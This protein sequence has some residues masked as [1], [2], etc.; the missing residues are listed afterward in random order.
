MDRIER[1]EVEN[2]KSYKGYQVIG[3]FSNFTAIIGPNGA[4]NSLS[5]FIIL[6]TFIY[7]IGKSNLMDAISFVL[8][9]RSN[10]LRGAQLTDLVYKFSEDDL[11]K[12]TRIQC[13]VRLI[14]R[15]SE[16]ETIFQRSIKIDSKSSEYRIDNKVVSF[17]DYEKRLSDFNIL[18]KAKNFLVF[19]GDVASVA[20]KTPKELTELIEQVSG[21]Y[22]YKDEYERL[23]KE[24]EQALENYKFI[25]KKSK[26]IQAEKKQYKVQKEE[27]DHYNQLKEKLINTQ[28]EHALFQLFY[29]KKD[30]D[31]FKEEIRKKE[32][33]L[34]SVGSKQNESES[35]LSEVK[36]KI[37]KIQN[38]INK[39][40]REI[41]GKRINIEKI[42]PS[43]IK[44]EKNVD[45]IR[46][47]I[48]KFKKDIDHL[49]NDMDK[50]N[51]KMKV[52]EDELK[53]IENH[54]RLWEKEFE[55][56]YKD[57]NITLTDA[58]QKE[59]AK[60][61]EEARSK[62]AID[63]QALS[64]MESNLNTKTTALS[65]IT[66]NIESLSRKKKQD[67]EALSV[68][69]NRK[70]KTEMIITSLVT[71]LNKVKDSHSKYSNSIENAK[72]SQ[73]TLNKRLRDVQDK[74]RIAKVEMSDNE[75]R[76]KSLE[77]LEN[78]KRLFPNVY[79][80]VIDLIHP[81]KSKYK[82]AVTVAIGI[83]IDSIVVAD[84]ST[85]FECIRYL[86]EQRL[87]VATFL[88]LNSLKTQV[89]N[90]KLRTLKYAT[91]IIDVLNYDEQFKTVAEYVCG[92]TLVTNDLDNA[93]KLA[94]GKER[95]KVVTLDGTVI[96]KSGLMTGG[97]SGVEQK[98][99]RWDEKE[100]EK[101][102]SERDQ[103]MAEIA[104]NGRILK[105]VSIEQQLETN[106]AEIETRLENVK[107]DLD[108]INSR[109][110]SLK[111]SIENV[112]NKIGE[113]TN[114]SNKLKK[115]IDKQNKE[116]D[117]LKSKINSVEDEIYKD[118]SA[119][120]GIPNIRVYEEHRRIRLKEKAEKDLFFSTQKSRI[121]NLMKYEQN[122]DSSQQIKGLEAKI[123][124]DEKQLKELDKK[125]KKKNDEIMKLNEEMES[126]R[127]DHEE[128]KSS[129]DSLVVE[130]RTINR[131][132][133]SWNKQSHHISQ[134]I[135]AKN[136]QIEQL[137][138]KRHN[139]LNQCI[140]D[141]IELPVENPPSEDESAMDIEEDLKDEDDIVFDFSIL[142]SKYKNLKTQA[143]RD[144]ANNNFLEE[145]RS[146]AIQ[147]DKISPNLK[148]IDHLQ[149]VNEKIEDLKKELLQARDE[150]RTKLNEFN[151]ISK[152]RSDA[153]IKSYDHISSVID[154]V[155]KQLTDHFGVAHLTLDSTEEPFLHGTRYI[156]VP[157]NKTFRDIEDL[158]G[159]E[160][161]VAAL[162]LLFA[163][164]SY[165]PSPFFVLDEV[166]AALDAN[167]VSIVA[168]YF[169]EK[170][171][172]VQFIL[173]SLKDRCFDKAD[174][175]V[176][177][178]ID[179][180]EDCSRTL[181]LDLTKYE[182]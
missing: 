124:E 31:D 182:Q 122:K 58:Q 153:F 100:I 69:E 19:Q 133:D 60:I 88:P 9:I 173:I 71:E 53:E 174:S 81:S 146:N 21:S 142:K 89:I 172:D 52:Y 128:K 20:S 180:D 175:L 147:L 141:D 59:L 162:A 116:I 77:T 134:V 152:L 76:D 127:K 171:K 98:A 7:L 143:Q 27:A 22:Q 131:E 56:K 61:K 144:E 101:L 8:G 117:S 179:R 177:I 156:A 155:Y 46:V 135:E 68:L 169:R 4:G 16:G 73:E 13:F 2:F 176:G 79:G 165:K 62:T 126:L 50:H 72:S 130:M 121:E 10:K 178:Y 115:D 149:S 54:Q 138:E 26:G 47:R 167:N 84:E 108:N 151:K 150:A 136:S 36:K 40:N 96:Q 11:E 109:I 112:N 23:Y 170:S 118:F 106:I 83:H 70:E 103:I 14:F 63:R 32:N 74:L 158:S 93:R 113:Y 166:D 3:P 30:I 44:V 148:A 15:H 107:C 145:I 164:H 65:Q 85:A 181:T 24:K 75:R 51:E 104:E 82:V 168:K 34:K 160:K 12:M 123:Q 125:L 110:K 102:R 42:A 48:Q 97:I 114:E 94:F 18:I 39:L 119:K 55:E 161:S 67:E 80:R 1:L 5:C 99:K 139:I 33:D 17:E 95:Y 87:G 92:N 137:K 90:D 132:I 163:I 159:G 41:E 66:S 43:K 105:N 6:H 57:V 157:R 78:L 129:L 38:E 64:T 120:V 140:L 91:P 29:I 111:E 49:K 35:K 86:R 37:G 45:Y 25:N 28:I 154:E